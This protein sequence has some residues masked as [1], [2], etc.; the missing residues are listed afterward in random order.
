MKQLQLVVIRVRPFFLNS[1]FFFSVKY[2]S[3]VVVVAAAFIML[4]LFKR[5]PLFWRKQWLQMAGVPKCMSCKHP[6]D[7]QEKNM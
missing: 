1:E 4:F 7:L 5:W 3:T 6:W 2:K